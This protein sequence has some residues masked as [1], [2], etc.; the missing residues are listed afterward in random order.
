MIDSSDD[1]SGG[2]ADNPGLISDYLRREAWRFRWEKRLT[3][4]TVALI[5]LFYLALLGFVFLGNIRISAGV[6]YFF[7]A[8]RPHSAG[9]IPIIVSLST[10]PTLLLIALLR[11]FHHRP[12]ADQDDLQAP[13]PISVE[14]AK[15]IIKA[16]TDAMK[17]N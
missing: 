17:N 16:T 4:V 3:N 12:K 8:V 7:A 11:Y 13:L 14:A 1:L 15:A 5:L 2:E 9:D 6:W 10:V